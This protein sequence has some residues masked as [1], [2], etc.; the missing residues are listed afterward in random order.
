MSRL[1]QLAL[2]L[3][4]GI[5][6]VLARKLLDHYGN[7]DVLFSRSAGDLM[8]I[9]GVGVRLARSFEPANCEKALMQAETQL[10]IIENAGARILF[11]L[12]KDYPSRLKQCYDA[13]VVLFCKGSAGPERPRVLSVVGSRRATAAGK[14]L[15]QSLIRDLAEYNPLIVSGLA[16]GIDVTAHRAALKNGLPTLGVLGHG[17]GSIYPPAHYRIS[18]EIIGRGALLSEFLHD[19]PAAPENFPRRN[20]I[21]AGLSDATVVIEAGEKG[22]ALITAGIASSYDRD[23]FAL[24]GR[25]NDANAAGCLRLIRD[26]KAQLITRASDLAWYLGWDS[27][28]PPLVKNDHH[29]EYL[30]KEEQEILEMIQKSGGAT[31]DELDSELNFSRNTLISNI[32]K[33]EL[34]GFIENVPGKGYFY[35]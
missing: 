5:G 29:L 23:V 9:P 17:L 27:S 22:G 21:I 1:K 28:G 6:P 18:R 20:R 35:M 13:P 19:A 8:N 7:E 34:S 33:L 10:K 25:V 26:Q 32:F 14:L 4:P 3:L 24:P 31:I 2:T 16:Y 12:D 15:C 30:S 11:Y